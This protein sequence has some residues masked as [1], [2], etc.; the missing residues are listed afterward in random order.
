M[1]GSIILPGKKFVQMNFGI[2]AAHNSRS[3]RPV[4]S[5]CTNDALEINSMKNIFETKAIQRI[6]YTESFFFVSAQDHPAAKLFVIITC[7]DFQFIH[8]IRSKTVGDAAAFV[9]RIKTGEEI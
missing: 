8:F 3:L 2:N 9:A 7:R 5:L 4:V 1:V 6:I